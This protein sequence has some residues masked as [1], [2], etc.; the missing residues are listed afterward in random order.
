MDKLALYKQIFNCLSHETFDR[1]KAE[2]LNNPMI[3]CKKEAF[4]LLCEYSPDD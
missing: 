3:K 1:L 4:G 2:V